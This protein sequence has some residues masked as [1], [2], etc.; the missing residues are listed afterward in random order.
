MLVLLVIVIVSLIVLVVIWKQV[1]LWNL[2]NE[3]GC[4]F[5]CLVQRRGLVIPC[6]VNLVRYFM[7]DH[8]RLSWVQSL[9]FCS[10]A[11]LP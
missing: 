5:Q 6:V 3:N 10:E 11:Q 7:V 1:S 9:W 8:G 2:Q 4:I